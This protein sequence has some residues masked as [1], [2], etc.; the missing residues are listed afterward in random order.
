ML[1]GLH[2]VLA[3]AVGAG[4]GVG[5]FNV[6]HLEHAEALVG[7][8]EDAGLPVVLQVS[9]NTVRWHGSLA[10]LAAATRAV[11]EQSPAQVVLPTRL[12]VRG[13]TAAPREPA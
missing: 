13:S 7:A 8:A 6:I 9:E 5:A 11:G 2:E 1:V 4:R 12:V 10:P 3:Q